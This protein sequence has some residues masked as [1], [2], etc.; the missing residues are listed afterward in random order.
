MPCICVN[1]YGS[2]QL[3]VFQC[4]HVCH[5]ACADRHYAARLQ[6]NEEDELDEAEE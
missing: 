5:A 4:G 1:P 2:G 6:R 3:V